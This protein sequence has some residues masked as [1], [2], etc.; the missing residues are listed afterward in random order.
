MRGPFP[1]QSL[2]DTEKRL[3][4][5]VPIHRQAN[6]TTPRVEQHLDVFL[7][8]EVRVLLVFPAD[9]LRSFVHP[10][11]F[12]R[13]RVAGFGVNRHFARAEGDRIFIFLLSD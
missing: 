3:V 7:F 9:F 2:P 8:R 1:R 12:A 5:T 6:P 11:H 4:L 10:E 13:L